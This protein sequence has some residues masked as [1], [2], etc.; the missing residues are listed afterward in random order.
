M[1]EHL[2]G[3]VT[4]AGLSVQAGPLA[5]LV[6]LA[7][8]IVRALAAPFLAVAAGA[9][10]DAAASHEQTRTVA[11]SLGLAACV[12]G[13][14]LLGGV[15]AHILA[16]LQREVGFRLECLL[17]EHDGRQLGLEHHERPDYLAYLDLL[18][19]DSW[20]LLWALEMVVQAV[21]LAV[22]WTATAAI[23]LRLQPALLALPLCGLPALAAA[24]RAERLVQAAR[25]RVVEQRRRERHLFDLG[26][27]PAAGKEIRVFGLADT[28][29]QRRRRAADIIV[30]A[31]HRAQRAGALVQTLGQAAFTAGYA[32][33]I[34]LVAVRAL[35]GAAS[36]GDVVVVAGLAGQVGG[37]VGESA[38]AFSGA[39]G[40]LRVL[41]RLR[42]LEQYAAEQAPLRAAAGVA[43][44]APGRLVQGID[45]AGVSFRY[46]G[47][48]A[49][50][51]DG[52][53][54]HLPAGATVALV[55]ENGAGKT[56]LVK[57]LCRFYEPTAGQILVDGIALARIGVE[58]WR[59]RLAGAF[60]DYA[61][62]EVTARET[63]GVGDSPRLEQAGD[64]A[65]LAA[66]DRAGAGGVLSAL[67][68]GLNTLLGAGWAGA[69]ELSGGQWQ[70][71]ALGRARMR[72]HPLLL[73]LD[74]P[75]AALDAGAEHALFERFAGAAREVRENGGITLLVSHRFSTVRMADLIVVL[76]G[77]RVREV[78]THADLMAQQGLYAELYTLQ[79]RAYTAEAPGA[80]GSLQSS[81]D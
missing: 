1:R 7:L 19:G 25:E 52:I 40:I 37:L 38:D 53:T 28:L 81:G 30:G 49:P 70:K 67:P 74:E 8:S 27:S 65:V 11:A 62:F 76:D 66:L 46:P 43:V 44:A 13:R 4:V 48:A 50:V 16:R 63:V 36:A 22:Q 58:D 51:L 2:R 33:A 39:L 31:Q 47:S 69:V 26:L 78:G 71:L 32:G 35:S 20:R 5:S 21:T 10:V 29:A 55:G 23:L 41:A 75:T 34:A 73:V 14:W 57:L 59:L 60:Q 56:T 18:R 45:L 79:A 80:R 6:L 24:M 17:I 12:G 9:L 72:P 61:R 42:W 64:A 68:L 3:L 77:Q 15:A 54:L